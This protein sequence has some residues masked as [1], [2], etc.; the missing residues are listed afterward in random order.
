[1]LCLPPTA[2]L[3]LLLSPGSHGGFDGHD[4]DPRPGDL[5][6]EG[7]VQ[8]ARRMFAG[9][10]EEVLPFSQTCLSCFLPPLTLLAWPDCL[11]QSSVVFVPR[12]IP[13]VFARP[14]SAACPAVGWA[15]GHGPRCH[16]KLS[17][18]PAAPVPPIGTAGGGHAGDP[19]SG[20]GLGTLH[21]CLKAGQQGRRGTILC[22]MVKLIHLCIS[23][24]FCQKEVVRKRQ[25]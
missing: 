21:C 22:G 5:A 15:A 19:G 23:S 2:P 17:T 4:R 9:S 25:L 16:L 13:G 3:P 7:P 20:A 6:A 10:S 11:G 8:A 14:G 18:A 24:D 12:V 1:M